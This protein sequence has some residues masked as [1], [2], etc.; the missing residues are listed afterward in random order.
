[1]PY[2]YTVEDRIVHIAWDGTISRQDLQSVDQE[3]PRLAVR[4][5]FG[6]NVLHTFA[7]ATG[8]NYE[9]ITAYMVSLIRKRIAIP[10]PVK[11]A[12]VATTPETK[13]MAELFRE[14]DAT[15]NL[16]IEVFASEAAAREWLDEE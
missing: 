5:G 2:T 10:H 3:M 12:L 13:R 16:T 14:L 11:S 4:L 9:L 7:E 8:H 1:M 15:P 6:P